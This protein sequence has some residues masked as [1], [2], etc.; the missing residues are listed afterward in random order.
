MAVSTAVALSL[1]ATA[2]VMQR[3]REVLLRQV[4]HHDADASVTAVMD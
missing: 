3:P 4:P 1:L 2:L